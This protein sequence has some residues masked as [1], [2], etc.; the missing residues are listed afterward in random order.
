M[1]SQHSVPLDPNGA[2][3]L[4]QEWLALLAF[5]A[6]IK[7]LLQCRCNGLGLDIQRPDPVNFVLPL[8]ISIKIYLRSLLYQHYSQEYLFNWNITSS[9]Y[10]E[11]LLISM[12]K[13]LILFFLSDHVSQCSILLLK[14]CGGFKS[15]RSSYSNIF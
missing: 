11:M 4:V 8:S 5:V 10:L 3:W 9:P 15:R 12:I 2:F 1:G 7:M 6:L 13:W 14:I